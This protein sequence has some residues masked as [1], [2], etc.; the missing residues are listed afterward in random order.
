MAE[1]S[2]Q[3][4]SI[5][6]EEL[7]RGYYGTETLAKALN[8]MHQDGL[9]VLRDVIP[10]A[11]LDNLNKKMCHDAEEKISDPSQGYNHGI[12]SNILQR[13]PIFDARYLSKEVYFNPFLLQVA[14]AYLGHKPIWNWLTSNVALAKTGG[15][16]Q[17]VHKDT[18]YEHPQF[19]YYFIANIPLCDFNIENGATEFWLGSHAHTTWRDQAM[20]S[21][22]E[23]TKPY[24]EG[25]MDDPLPAI[26]EEAKEIRIKT[27]PPVQPMC[28]KGDIMIRDLRTWHA[29][30]PNSSQEHRVM[31]GL[32][33]QSPFHGNE[34]MHVHLPLSQDNFFLDHDRDLVEV[35]A[36]WYQ[37][38]ELAN[39]QA[40]T[41]FETR[42]CYTR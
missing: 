22:L 24:A 36:K 12:K 31:L 5:S 26:S 28:R 19:P 11:I 15:I 3:S 35:R 1:S 9:V 29:G 10:V 32:G 4:I 8:A 6:E 38:D 13:P 7:Q 37:D 41:V 2:A 42:P 16:R 25:S 33:Y 14:N 18:R 23:D 27:R 17:P 21:S 20:P 30:M 40:D 39:T 34:T